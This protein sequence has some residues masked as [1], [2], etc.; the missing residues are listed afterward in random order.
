MM[1]LKLITAGVLCAA[2]ALGM[3]SPALANGATSFRNIVILGTAAALTLTNWNHKRHI[4]QEEMQE[5]GRRQQA[6][7]EWYYQKYGHYP[8]ESEFKDWY[9]KTYGV[10]PS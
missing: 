3:A 6:Y 4:K 1:K 10:Q 7:R 5:Q 8:T 2:I 9:V